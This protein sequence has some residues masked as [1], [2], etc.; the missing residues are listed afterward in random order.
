MAVVH[1]ICGG[2]DVHQ[3]HLTAC[4]RRVTEDSQVT[5][6]V[7]EFATTSPALLAWLDWLSAQD[8]PVVAVESTGV[9]WRPV[10]H[11]LAGTIEVVVGHAQE[12]RRRP[13]RKTDKADARWIAELLAHGLIRPILAEGTFYDEERY[14]RLQPRQE[15]Q[16]RKRAVRALERLGYQV[17]L[18]RVA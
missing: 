9:Y 6:E 13:G 15:E 17:T 3:A 12:M 18:E 14:D 11:V 7:R 8:C 1:P 16:Q 4:L 2:I 10:Y 5:Q